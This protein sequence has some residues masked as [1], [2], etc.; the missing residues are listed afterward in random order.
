MQSDPTGAAGSCAVR[1]S[2]DVLSPSQRVIILINPYL[3]LYR[4]YYA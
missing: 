4:Y 1:Y 2:M 3:T